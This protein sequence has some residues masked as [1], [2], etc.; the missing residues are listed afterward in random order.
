MPLSST[1]AVRLT[2]QRRRGL[3]VLAC[4]R[5]HVGRIARRTEPS[6]SRI[7]AKVALWL[8]DTGL[9][10]GHPIEGWIEL[11]ERGAELAREEG[12]L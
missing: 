8:L 5:Q 4:N 7:S 3:Q 11:T 9:A 6:R 2:H 12:L 10:G 1:A